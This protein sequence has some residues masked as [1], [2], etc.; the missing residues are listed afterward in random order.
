MAVWRVDEE[1]VKETKAAV[2]VRLKAGVRIFCR[3]WTL[4]EPCHSARLGLLGAV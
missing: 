4:A 1:M 3:H 2:N